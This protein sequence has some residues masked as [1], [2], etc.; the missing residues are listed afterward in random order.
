[1]AL[2][3]VEELQDPPIVGRMYLVRCVWW[4]APARPRW[5]P[6]IGHLHE[7]ADLG[8]PT[9][10]LHYDLRFLPQR[11]LGG[12][13][14]EKYMHLTHTHEPGERYAVRRLRCLREQPTFPY[15]E[16]LSNTLRAFEQRH[17]KMW[18]RKDCRTC[19]HRGMALTQVPVDAEGGQVC[20]GH[21]L[22]WNRETGH[23]MPRY[24]PRPR[25]AL[26]GANV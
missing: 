6:V 7:D 10:H 17:E 1:M 9:T 4:T 11:V 12:R 16:S 15:P 5:M 14:P 2:Q 3:R 19:P 8:V 20:P 24:T 13:S 18:V 25:A 23:L 26:G 22:R 21:G